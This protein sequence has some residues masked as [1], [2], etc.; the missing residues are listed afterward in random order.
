MLPIRALALASI[1]LGCTLA[2]HSPS[3]PSS[4]APSAAPPPASI[5]TPSATGPAPSPLPTATTPPDVVLVV[6][7]D[8]SWEDLFHVATPNM[9]GLALQGQVCTSFY[10]HPVCSPTRIGL[11]FGIYSVRE[12]VVGALSHHDDEPAMP[13]ERLALAQVLH[14]EGYATALFGKWHASTAGD[15]VTDENARRFGFE[16]WYAG[17]A[18]NIGKEGVASQINWHPIEDGYNAPVTHYSG[19]LITQEFE[20]WWSQPSTRPR[21]ASINYTT[22]HEPWTAPPPAFLPPGYTVGPNKRARF[23][24]SIA[25][26]DGFLGRVCAAI[27][28]STTYLL[29]LPDNGTPHNVVPPGSW[30]NGYKLTPW[31]GGV[32]VPLLVAGPGVAPGFNPHLMHAIDVP[33][34]ILE[35]CG[36]TAP[37]GFED[38]ESFA[39]SLFGAMPQR[40]PVVMQYKRFDPVTATLLVDDW[41]VVNANG[42]KL[43]SDAGV[44]RMYRLSSDPFETTPLWMPQ[45]HQS[46]KAVKQAIDP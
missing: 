43:V 13:A 42:M 20:T 31:Q 44:E 8:M 35:L 40:S 18:G 11:N 24:A 30:Y 26:L 34:T 15:G 10:T 38:G 6:L 39:P 12:G 14:A 23:E 28:L 22:P 45:L 19:D 16:H 33:E 9:I 2:T 32:H 29:V 41:A 7:D 36:L 1:V 4:A 25:A 27:D 3:S 17:V 46:L 5:P 37:F 21:F